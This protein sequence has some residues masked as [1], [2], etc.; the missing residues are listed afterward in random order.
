MQLNGVMLLSSILNYGMRDP[1]FDQI[2]IDYLPSY[3]AAAWYH[4]KLANKPADLP[5][6]LHEVRDWAARP[7]RPALAKGQD[8]SPE[9]EDAIAQQLAAYT[10]LSVPFILE[11]HLRV[12]LQRFRKE[13]LRDQRRTLGRYD[14]RFTGIDV[15]AAGEGP[16]YDPSD[17]GITGAFVAAFH[18]YL[19][20]RSGLR[21]RP[22]LS[23]EL[24]R[25]RTRAGTGSTSAPGQRFGAAAAARRGARPRRGHAREPA[26]AALFA[27]RLVRH[28]H[29]VL[30]H[31]VR[32]RP[33]AAR[34]VACAATC[35]SPTTRPATWS[36]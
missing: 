24:S 17:T 9:E 23:A 14:G 20:R 30:R 25:A 28:G 18:D 27:E 5:A 13:L 36:I 1:G 3:A 33:H 16:E 29:A 7:L 4:N 26:P 8:L 6:F 32:S 10:G 22:G 35:A 15:D 21:H 31:R 34:P 19:S 11:A 12:D 2:Y